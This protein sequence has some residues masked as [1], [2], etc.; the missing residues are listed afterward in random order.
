MN[1]KEDMSFQ[2]LTESVIKE[3][4][5]LVE[6]RKNVTEMI[7]A[8]NKMIKFLYSKIIVEEEQ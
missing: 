2:E 5:K 8:Q 3:E 6:W 7:N 4:E 1:K